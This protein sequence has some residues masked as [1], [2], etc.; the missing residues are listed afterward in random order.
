MLFGVYGHYKYF[1]LSVR[2]STLESDVCKRQI[3]TSSVDPRSARV[4]IIDCFMFVATLL[5]MQYEV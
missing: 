5:D 4:N 2:G 1:T 3:L